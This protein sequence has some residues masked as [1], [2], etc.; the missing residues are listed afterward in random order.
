MWVVGKHFVF[1]HEVRAIIPLLL[2][3]LYF[4]NM[5][6]ALVNKLV[7]YFENWTQYGKLDKYT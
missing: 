5:Y 2:T 6:I 3:K 1:G 7:I 4:Q